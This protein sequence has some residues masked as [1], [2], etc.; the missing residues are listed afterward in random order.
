MILLL[1]E[2]RVRMMN[3]MTAAVVITDYVLILVVIRGQIRCLLRI[4]MTETAH[5]RL[6]F[7]YLSMYH[8]TSHVIQGSY[9]KRLSSWTWLCPYIQIKKMFI[10]YPSPLL[11]DIT[12]HVPTNLS[13]IL[14]TRTVCHVI[15]TIIRMYL[16]HFCTWLAITKNRMSNRIL[17]SGY[18]A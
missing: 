14:T 13:S 17:E 9:C 18:A 4:W 3:F 15:I 6:T 5:P 2:I 8:F 11:I 16:F 10:S 7:I 12:I 1:P